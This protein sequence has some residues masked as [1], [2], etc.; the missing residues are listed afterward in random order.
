MRTMKLY[1]CKILTWL[2]CSLSLETLFS[3]LSKK[4]TFIMFPVIA[5]LITIQLVTLPLGVY[6]TLNHTLVILLLFTISYLL[7]ML[8]KCGSLVVGR[9]NSHIKDS[10]PKR[11]REVETQIV[12]MTRIVQGMIWLLGLSGIAMTFPNAWQVGVSLLAS[13]SVSA[14]LL[15]F[16][17]KPSIEVSAPPPHPVRAHVDK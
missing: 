8:I 13:A 15:G 7:V 1:A 14:L 9:N 10:A 12:V 4:P 2:V 5:L 3:L 17:A 6:G 11:A 16:A